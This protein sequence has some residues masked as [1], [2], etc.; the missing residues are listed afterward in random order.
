MTKEKME[1]LYKKSSE[2]INM[3][4]ELGKNNFKNYTLKLSSQGT[5]LTL[6]NTYISSSLKNEY[7]DDNL[8]NF[9][10]STTIEVMKQFE[11]DID[12]KVFDELEK[13]YIDFSK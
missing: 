4:T 13:A 8:N 12:N 5:F 3:M 1:L 11:S 6:S 7:T 2:Y 9:I 10:P